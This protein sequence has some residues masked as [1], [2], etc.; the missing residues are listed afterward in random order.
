[1]NSKELFQLTSLLN[2]NRAEL[3]GKTAGQA[4]LWAAGSL[5]SMAITAANLAHAA[6][7]ID[8][9][10]QRAQRSSTPVTTNSG[11]LVKDRTRLLARELVAFM[12]MVNEKPSEVLA[13]LAAGKPVY[14]QSPTADDLG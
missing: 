14:L 5:P 10:F 12:A 4:L 3:S 11:A 13:A 6:S 9:K 1:M 8:L 2:T 7:A